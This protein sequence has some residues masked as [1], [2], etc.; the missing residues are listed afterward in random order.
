[1]QKLSA[2]QNVGTKLNI[3]TRIVK[4]GSW[5]EDSIDQVLSKYNSEQIELLCR[6][7]QPIGMQ[8]T[9]ELMRY[10]LKFEHIPKIILM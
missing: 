9:N 2:I 5:P 10:Q 1:V 3:R 4:L 6:N 8:E 7:C